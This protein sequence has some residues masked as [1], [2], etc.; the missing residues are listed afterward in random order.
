MVEVAALKGIPCLDMWRTLGL[1]I[2]N[3]TSLTFDGEHPNEAGATRRGE[4]VASFIN[5]VFGRNHS[6]KIALFC[7][8][9]AASEKSNTRL[10]RDCHSFQSFTGNIFQNVS[11]T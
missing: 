8:P 4:A 9:F 1:N 2:N 5:S 3:Y 7:L 10:S 11:R 6:N